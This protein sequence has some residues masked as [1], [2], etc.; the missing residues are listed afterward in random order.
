MPASAHPIGTRIIHV[1]YEV[2]SRSAEDPFFKALLGFRPYWFGAMQ[3][4]KLDWVSQQTPDGH[5]WLEY[6]LVG[7]GADTPLDKITANEL[8]VLNHFSIG[9]P[10]ME[11]AVTTLWT[12]NRFPPRHDGPRHGQGRQVAS[13]PLRPRRHP[14]RAHGVRPRRSTL[15]LR[16]H[17]PKSHPTPPLTPSPFRRP[18]RLLSPHIWRPPARLPHASV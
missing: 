5:D 10:N 17:R 4:A 6:M 14:R 18:P 7:P 2:H 11:A 1:G 12:G 13:Q 15:L 16:L 9:V 3:P 8:G